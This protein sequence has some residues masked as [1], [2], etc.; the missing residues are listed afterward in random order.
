[1]VV[2]GASVIFNGE[3][4]SASRFVATPSPEQCDDSLPKQVY[5][6]DGVELTNESE[7]DEILFCKVLYPINGLTGSS[8]LQFVTAS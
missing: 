6:T 8:Y 5:S 4:D 7:L 2:L 3:T 1:M